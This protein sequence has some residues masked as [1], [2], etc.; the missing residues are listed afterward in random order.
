MTPTEHTTG[1]ERTPTDMREVQRDM[2]EWQFMRAIDDMIREFGSD[3][4]REIFEE[5]MK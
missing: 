5:M 4:T 1:D 2:A 3:Y